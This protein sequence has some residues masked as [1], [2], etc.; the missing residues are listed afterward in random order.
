MKGE[1]HD[2]GPVEFIEI[3]FPGNQFNS[4]IVLALR[5]LVDNGT[6]QIID[7]LFVK[8]D[9]VGNVQYF[10]WT[11]LRAR[12]ARRSTISTASSAIS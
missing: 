4:E 2:H 5:E 1:N 11:H 10:S 7:L 3:A 9:A 12:R 6:I 8:K